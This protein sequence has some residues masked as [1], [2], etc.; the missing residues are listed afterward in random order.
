M[1]AYPANQSAQ[2]IGFDKSQQIAGAVKSL[3]MTIRDESLSGNISRK[4]LIDF[5]AQLNR[6]HSV[7]GQIAGIEGI[8]AY[9]RREIDDPTFDLVTAFVDMRAQ[10]AATRDW[11]AANFPKTGAAWLVSSYDSAGTETVLTFTTAQTAG[12]RT[13]CDSLIATIE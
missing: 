12:L 13:E 8:Q 9:A 1:P 3:A 7:L 6:H 10:I 2:R 11:V 5:M 4:R